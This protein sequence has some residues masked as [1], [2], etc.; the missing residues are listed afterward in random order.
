[1]NGHP[2]HALGWFEMKNNVEYKLDSCR[3]MQDASNEYFYNMKASNQWTILSC[4]NSEPRQFAKDNFELWV[5]END[6]EIIGLPL[7]L[8]ISSFRS[9]TF[10]Q[11]PCQTVKC[12]IPEEQILLDN[13]YAK[14]IRNEPV[15]IFLL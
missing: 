1:M 4:F 3:G 10:E 13:R 5:D 12:V 9:L 8:N 7:K 6:S 15:Q 11:Q 14:K 2:I